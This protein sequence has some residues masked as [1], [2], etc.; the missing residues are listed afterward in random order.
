MNALEQHL[1]RADAVLAGRKAPWALLGGWA[2]SIR[3]EPRFTR[4]VDLAVAVASDEEAESI[5]HDFRAKGYSPDAVV[6]QDA[7]HRLATVR[8]VPVQGDQGILLDLLFASSGIENEVCA[9]A[10]RMEVLPGLV[11]PVARP[12]HLL[13]LKILARDDRTRPQDAGDIAALL[14]GM[15]E[16]ALQA[17]RRALQLIQD[18]GYE[19]GRNLLSLFE[20]ARSEF[21]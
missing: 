8:L 10:E 16:P 9:A 19:R 3:T 13:A 5:I 11:V 18:R 12:E 1:R 17:T 4:D 7:V 14:R 15:D 20:S 6:E 21:A 2:V